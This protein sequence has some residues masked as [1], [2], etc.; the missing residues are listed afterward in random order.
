[1]KTLI[2]ASRV[3]PVEG[4]AFSEA[5]RKAGVFIGIVGREC[6]HFNLKVARMCSFP[7][8]PSF[9]GTVVIVI[10]LRKT[11]PIH[12][13]DMYG[14]QAANSA[15]VQAAVGQKGNI[16]LMSDSCERCVCTRVCVCVLHVC[17]CGCLCMNSSMRENLSVSGISW[18]RKYIAVRL[19]IYMS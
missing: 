2:R 6:R 1:M 3:S 16:N 4:G 9:H 7:R 13:V 19:R 12:T 10:M 5:F 15:S 11:I 8:S 18:G 14:F 17:V